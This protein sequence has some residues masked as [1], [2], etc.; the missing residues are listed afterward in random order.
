MKQEMKGKNQG[1]FHT[2]TPPSLLHPSLTLPNSPSPSVCP[3][4]YSPNLVSFL[5][6][7][8]R[9]PFP[10][11]LFTTAKPLPPPPPFP[12]A[13]PAAPLWSR[14]LLLW[15]PLLAPA[16]SAPSCRLLVLGDLSTGCC[17]GGWLLLPPL[18]AAF[19]DES[20]VELDLVT[21]ACSRRDLLPSSARRRS[22]SLS[23]SVF[24]RSRPSVL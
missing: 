7:T 22:L 4:I 11:E 24:S 9:V 2:C 15:P 21:G 1:I 5:L 16:P 20:R 12:L 13:P 18:A 17:C 14:R 6:P 19:R 8:A 3:K 10:S 23:L